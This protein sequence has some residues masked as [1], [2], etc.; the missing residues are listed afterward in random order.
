VSEHSGDSTR[1]AVRAQ[2]NACGITRA[3]GAPADTLHALLSSPSAPRHPTLIPSHHTVPT[4]AAATSRLWGGVPE[5]RANFAAPNAIALNAHQQG[6]SPAAF[7]G[8]GP[9]SSRFTALATSQD[10]N[11]KTFLA[12]VEAKDAPIYATQWHPEKV[13]YEWLATQASNHSAVSV[14]AN[15]YPALFFAQ[16]ARANGRA[17]GSASDEQAALIYNYEPVFTLPKISTEFEQ[18]YF[19]PAAAEAA[20]ASAGARGLRGAAGAA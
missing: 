15:G 8:N 9:L 11:G 13:A 17:F 4:R 6:V 20:A 18:C 16:Q 5:I 2:P 14:V 3:Q 12:S 10:R 1:E 19:F 7:A